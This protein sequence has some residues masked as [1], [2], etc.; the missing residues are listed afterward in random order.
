MY[1]TKCGKPISD[2]A[3]LCPE[4]E[5]AFPASSDAAANPAAFVASLNDLKCPSCGSGDFTI[6]GIKGSVGKALLNQLLFGAAGNL[7]AGNKAA[8]DTETHPLLYKCSKCKNKFESLPLP[9]APEDILP[10]PCDVTFI[11][12]SSFAGAAVPQIVY[13]NG[14]KVGAVKNGGSISFKTYNKNNLMFVTDHNNVVFQSYCRFEAQPGGS[15][16]KAF[17][18]KFL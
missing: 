7:V 10:V 17:K 11:R 12:E 16:T 9:A 14:V 2:E 18:M 1:C 8:K 6:I 15:V 13:I 3:A 5:Q 4:C